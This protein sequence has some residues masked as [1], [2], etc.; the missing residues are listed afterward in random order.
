MSPADY[1]AWY[2]SPRG[3]WIGQTEYRL[4]SNELAPFSGGQI[5]DVG[6]GTGWFTRQMATL[7]GQFVTG[8]DL[9]A[10]WLAFAR[11]RDARSTYLQA[12]ALALPFADNSFDHVL[13][14]AALCFTT[15]WHKAVSEIVRVT[16]RR[17]AIGM[18]NRNSLLW[19][20]KGR[21]GGSGAYRGALWLSPE[22]FG[23]SLKG[24]PISNSR[25]RS[26]I[27]LP[28]GSIT[29][30]T[31]ERLLPGSVP[32]GGFMVLTGDKK[33]VGGFASLPVSN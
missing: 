20:E 8:I 28:S 30:R 7:P 15:D 16:R 17:F 6:C 10:E 33:P 31:V 24:L 2:D 32:W 14:V 22:E 9:N 5:L 3:R 29:A 19:R 13:S 25:M 4:L 23:D 18:L 1:D 11:S 26:A 27:Y 12:N 21:H